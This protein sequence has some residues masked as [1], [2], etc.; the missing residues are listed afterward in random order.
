MVDHKKRTSGHINYSLLLKNSKGRET[1]I[2]I[3]MSPAVMKSCYYST[4]INTVNN[5]SHLGFILQL[6]TNDLHDSR[7][8]LYQQHYLG[9]G[10]EI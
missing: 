8:N 7:T 4:G 5:V 2:I 10:D 3:I 1:A 6:T 9:I